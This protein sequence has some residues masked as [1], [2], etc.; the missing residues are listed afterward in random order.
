[1]VD[2][3]AV[4][5][6]GNDVLGAADLFDDEGRAM[7]TACVGKTHQAG[8]HGVPAALDDAWRAW[9]SQV[10]LLGEACRTLGNGVV[11]ATRVHRE[12]EGALAGQGPGG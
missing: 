7:R 11:T 12:T 5:T 8:G 1:M 2:W 6:A 4:E 3:A 9:E 10:R